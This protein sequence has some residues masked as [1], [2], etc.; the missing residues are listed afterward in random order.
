MRKH[1]LYGETHVTTSSQNLT[2]SPPEILQIA[3][4]EEIFKKTIQQKLYSKKISNDSSSKSLKQFVHIYI[5]ISIT[6]LYHYT[7]ISL[8]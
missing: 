7:L 3:K 4:S 5:Y 1:S 8:C 6:S 2:D